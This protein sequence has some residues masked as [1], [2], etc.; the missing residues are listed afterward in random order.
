LLRAS[1]H[2]PCEDHEMPVRRDYTVEFKEQAADELRSAAVERVAPK[3]NVKPATTMNDSGRLL[4]P[5]RLAC[6][7]FDDRGDGHRGVEIAI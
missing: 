6:R 3:Q 4:D 2:D 7:C 1:N 5:G